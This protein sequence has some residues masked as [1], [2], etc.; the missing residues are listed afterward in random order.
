MFTENFR[1]LGQILH[2]QWPAQTSKIGQKLDF[3]LLGLKSRLSKNLLGHNKKGAYVTWLFKL[4]F[5]K[6]F[7]KLSLV[8]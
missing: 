5:T 2:P 8:I 6:E 4:L 7:Q 3:V 1:F